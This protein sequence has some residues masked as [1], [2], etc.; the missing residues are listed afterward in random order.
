MFVVLKSTQ[1]DDVCFVKKVTQKSS[2]DFVM[3][4]FIFMRA[5][6]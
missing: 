5:L 3:Y 4:I 2:V 1:Q 6:Q